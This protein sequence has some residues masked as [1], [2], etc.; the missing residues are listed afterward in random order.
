MEF[1]NLHDDIDFNCINKDVTENIKDV[2]T[3]KM[4]SSVL[5][6]DDFISYWEMGRRP[7]I[8]EKENE[9]LRHGIFLEIFQDLLW[10]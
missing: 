9:I 2:F 1:Q 4:K 3:R 6:N 8:Q 5:Q 7:P 10:K